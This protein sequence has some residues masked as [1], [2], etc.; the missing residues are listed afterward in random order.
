MIVWSILFCTRFLQYIIRGWSFDVLLPSSF[1]LFHWWQWRN[2]Y[3]EY[4]RKEYYETDFVMYAWHDKARECLVSRQC[5]AISFFFFLLIYL[6]KNKKMITLVL[7]EELIS[8]L[9]NF[10]I[11]ISDLF[12]ICV[13]LIIY[14]E[15]CYY[16]VWIS[17]SSQ[18]SSLQ[19]SICWLSFLFFFRILVI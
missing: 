10:I 18:S 6:A 2:C 15:I 7:I 16:S 17:L 9:K 11:D 14:V 3:S 12:F 4:E 5:I 19:V 8:H 1:F 13:Q